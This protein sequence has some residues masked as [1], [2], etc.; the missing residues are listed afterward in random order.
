MLMNDIIFTISKHDTLRPLGIQFRPFAD[1]VH[2]I[3]YLKRCS[4]A[5]IGILE[6]LM[7]HQLVMFRL[8]TLMALFGSIGCIL[9]RCHALLTRSPMTLYV[10]FGNEIKP[11]CS[12][13]LPATTT[14]TIATKACKPYVFPP[15]LHQTPRYRSGIKARRGLRN[16]P[17][18]RHVLQQVGF[19]A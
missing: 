5:C 3:K 13:C 2:D 4:K 10:F 18:K 1:S 6:H 15:I 19:C 8:F 7:F 16:G 14:I 11:P 9:E 17:H 12:I